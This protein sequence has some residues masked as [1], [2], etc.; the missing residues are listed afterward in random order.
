MKILSVLGLAYLLQCTL[1]QILPVVNSPLPEADSQTQAD[2]EYVR[3]R[4]QELHQHEAEK[5]GI[6]AE[7][8]IEEVTEISDSPTDIPKINE[9]ISEYL[10][11]GDILLTPEQADHIVE[12]RHKRQALNLNVFRQ[13]RWPTNSSISYHF[14]QG[15]NANARALIKKSLLFWEDHTCLSFRENG[16][17]RPSIQFIRGKGCFS[18]IGRVSQVQIQQISI[19]FGG[20]EHVS[21]FQNILRLYL[22]FFQFGIITHEVGHA[23]GFYHEQ[24]RCDR[25]EY[26]TIY[27]NNL[28]QNSAGNFVKSSPKDNNNYKIPYD[29]GSVMHYG[30]YSFAARHGIPTI[31]PIKNGRRN[32]LDRS[33]MG[34]RIQ[35][36]F[37][38]VF[39]MN[40][41]Y[42]C[43]AKCPKECKNDGFPHPKKCE[44]ICPWGFEGS[45]CDTR[46]RGDN[47]GAIC[48][49]DL[50]A[51]ANWQTL[52]ATVGKMGQDKQIHDRCHW[53]IN[54]GSRLFNP[55]ML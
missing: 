40:K 9:A 1:G 29:Y 43:P 7:F 30:E 45:T 55:K 22:R 13:A 21:H 47:G 33:T 12:Y 3:T 54:V 4:L 36:S 5:N 16:P 25:D 37:Y 27:H 41:H 6:Q 28:L 49:A 46:A 23:L 18:N 52:N 42:Q 8:E 51:T 31:V 53:H 44:C 14:A 2:L 24:S 20:C 17:T 35:P 10:F 26:V 48:G 32:P 50:Q 19:G 15:F 38:D 34:Q 39:M 11:Q